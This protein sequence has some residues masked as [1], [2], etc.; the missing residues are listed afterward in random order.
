LKKWGAGLLTG[1]EERGILKGTEEV[2]DLNN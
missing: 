2:E 1:S